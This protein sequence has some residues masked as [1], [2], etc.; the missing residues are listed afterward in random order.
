VLGL[1]HPDTLA[2]MN[3]E[4][5]KDQDAAQG[6]QHLHQNGDSTAAL[7]EHAALTKNFEQRMFEET[8]TAVN[9]MNKMEKEWKKAKELWHNQK[10]NLNSNQQE[11]CS[12]RYVETSFLGQELLSSYQQHWGT[13]SYIGCAGHSQDTQQLQLQQ[14]FQT[15]GYHPS[16]VQ[17]HSCMPSSAPIPPGSV[18]KQPQS[19]K[20][21]AKTL[22]PE[23]SETCQSEILKEHRHKAETFERLV[24]AFSCGKTGELAEHNLVK[25]SGFE[26]EVQNFLNDDPKFPCACLADFKMLADHRKE[27]PGVCHSD[28]ETAGIVVIKSSSPL[29]SSLVPCKISCGIWQK[30]DDAKLT[31][32][33]K[34][35]VIVQIFGQK[36]EDADSSVPEHAPSLEAGEKPTII[37]AEFRCFTGTNAED[38]GDLKLIDLNQ[39]LA[40]EG[41]TLLQEA[42]K[43][44]NIELR[45]TPVDFSDYCDI[46]RKR[47]AARRSNVP[48]PEIR[49]K[50]LAGNTDSLCFLIR[51]ANELSDLNMVKESGFQ[52]E[53]KKFLNDPDLAWTCLAGVRKPDYQKNESYGISGSDCKILGV[54]A[55]KSS[56]GTVAPLRISARIWLRTKDLNVIRRII[57]QIVLQ[58]FGANPMHRNHDV[59]RNHHTMEDVFEKFPIEAVVRC[60]CD[61]SHKEE[62]DEE[63][64]RGLVIKLN[65]ALPD[66]L[67][68]AFESFHFTLEGQEQDFSEYADLVAKRLKA[69]P[70]VDKRF[71]WKTIKDFKG[72]WLPGNLFK[73]TLSEQLSYDLEKTEGHRKELDG[74]IVVLLPSRERDGGVVEE[75][76]QVLVAPMDMRRR[77]I[78][79]VP[80]KALHPFGIAKDQETGSEKQLQTDNK[81]KELT[82]YLR[83]QYQYKVLVRQEDKWR[84]ARLCLNM[85]GAEC[86]VQ[87]VDADEKLSEP[88]PVNA[89]DLKLAKA[90]PNIAAKLGAGLEAATLASSKPTGET[91]PH[92]RS[93]GTSE[94]LESDSE[95]ADNLSF[96]IKDAKE[97]GD[98]DMV[99]ESG[100]QSEVQKFF[101]PLE[102]PDFPWTCLADVSEPADGSNERKGSSDNQTKTLGV[103]AIK[104]SNGFGTLLKISA[105]IWLRREDRRVLRGI[106]PQIVLQ[107]FGKAPLQKNNDV[108]RNR[109]TLPGVGKTTQIEVHLC[110][111]IKNEES[112]QIEK[113]QPKVDQIA[114]KKMLARDGL[115]LLKAALVSLNSMLTGEEQD[116]LD[117]ADI[118]AHRLKV[119]FDKRSNEGASLVDKRPKWQ[120]IK[121]FEGRWLPGNLFKFRLPEH[122]SFD[123]EK[124]GGYQKDLD[125]CI[126]VLLPWNDC[127]GS[128]QLKEEEE[129]LVAAVDSRR[130]AIYLVPRI[131]LHPVSIDGKQLQPGTEKP[132][133]LTKYLEGKYQYK[134]LVRSGGT[135]ENPRKARLCL[136]VVGDEINEKCTVQFEDEGQQ[137]KPE[138]VNVS[139]L[140]LAKD[141]KNVKSRGGISA[142]HDGGGTI[143][144]SLATTATS[145]HGFHQGGFARNTMQYST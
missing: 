26:S 110:C 115:P 18:H 127:H 128:L 45:G 53:V 132:K 69:R 5:C 55:I 142:Q 122:L 103:V 34:S 20:T 101:G 67:Q 22:K 87:F 48:K 117:Y 113:P 39:A 140:R 33:I 106:I 61:E 28:T 133:E 93:I 14:H 139:D 11:R 138:A 16:M 31:R 54:V 59:R 90:L 25:E 51:D 75:A 108:R 43:R 112:Q 119:P 1:E 60:F 63:N 24:G 8:R 107:V 70:E 42:F 120:T 89:N 104:S 126:V 71:K 91:A 10:D 98:L 83:S 35:E 79:L 81:L 118:V 134:V 136:E 56:D 73:V 13:S 17:G 64:E 74:H 36:P 50:L 144:S 131:A 3:K 94:M 46:V 12:P 123:L 23:K 66:S 121:D 78:Y 145:R 30:K 111:F 125:G 27:N 102:D 99:K 68:K 21:Q 41:L 82:T 65:Q 72:E 32:H 40:L 92:E 130:R 44:S 124:T 97:L 15:Q 62:T 96:L 84:R 37:T 29:D 9:T 7:T 135:W 100:F 76:T 57:A 4:E 137:A 49:E 77:A 141:F 86:I 6:R 52:S 88:Q 2:S 47:L 116:F 129:A 105:G 58:V 19:K 109:F 80:R 143:V 95:F 38:A 114:I 85:V